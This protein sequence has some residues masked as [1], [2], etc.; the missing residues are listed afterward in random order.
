MTESSP[1]TWNLR[2]QRWAEGEPNVRL[3]L[4]VGSQ[5]RTD[6]PADSFSDIDLALFAR[7]PNRILRDESWISGLGTYWTSHLEGNA[8]ESGEERRVLFDDGQD[9][10]FAVFPMESLGALTADP[11]AVTIL[12]RGFRPLVNKDSVE[13]ILPRDEPAPVTPSLSDF[14]NLVSDYWFHLVWTAKKL[15]RGELLTAL[16]ATNGCLRAI[17]IRAIRLH[18]VAR[19]PKGRDLWNSARFF[20]KWADPREIRD[21]PQTVAQY[22]ALSIALALRANRELFAWLIDELRLTLAF[23]SP[24]H[25]QP[26]LSSYLDSLLD[27]VKA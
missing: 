12:R 4:L 18:A 25:D 2:L 23:A 5:A 21:F 3:A 13:L 8:L 9:V 27:Q 14:S 6:M 26:G 7:D 24:I 10:D 15:R 17:L 22:D 11:R 1:A 16:E 19:G 20:E